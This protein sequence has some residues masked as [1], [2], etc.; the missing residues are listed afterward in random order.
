MTCID[1]G[2]VIGWLYSVLIATLKLGHFHRNLMDT[3]IPVVVEY[4]NRFE[5][6]QRV[7]LAREFSVEKWLPPRYVEGEGEEKETR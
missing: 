4:I 7:D 3:F 1:V 2:V 5:V 6:T